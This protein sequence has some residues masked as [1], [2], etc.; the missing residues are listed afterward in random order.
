[1]I[2]NVCQGKLPGYPPG[3]GTFAHARDIADAHI[4]A[5]DKGR[6]GENYLLG[7][8]RASFKEVISQIIDITQMDLS[9]GKISKQ[10]LQMILYLGRVKSF[11]DGKEPLLTYPKFIRLTGKLICDDTKAQRE[12]GFKTTTIHKM[13]TDCYG[14]MKQ[15][16]LI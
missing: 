9:L 11:F 7:G 8:V 15:E 12:L 3:L 6:N 1:L 10:K 5:V 14:W 2:K 16:K 13:L 4:A